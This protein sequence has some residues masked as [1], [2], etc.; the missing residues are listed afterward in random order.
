[1]Q[2][3]LILCIFLTALTPAGFGAP[4]LSDISSSSALVSV[5]GDQAIIPG[6][7]MQS[8]QHVSESISTLS[9]AGADVSTWYRVSPRGTIMAGLL[10]NSVYNDS[11]LFFS[12]NLDTEVDYSTFNVPWLYREEFLLSPEPGQHYFMQT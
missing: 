8:T 1:M 4:S 6:W 3:I 12:N 10:E 11:E 7:Y 2:A 9:R 5:A